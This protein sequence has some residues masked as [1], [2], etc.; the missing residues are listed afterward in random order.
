MSKCQFVC[1]LVFSIAAAVS[2][3]LVAIS[4]A[5]A[6]EDNCTQTGCPD[7]QTCAGHDGINYVC[8]PLPPPTEPDEPGEP[9][10]PGVYDPFALEEMQ[11]SE[12]LAHDLMNAGLTFEDYLAWKDDLAS[13]GVRV[14]GDDGVGYFIDE[15]L[16]EEAATPTEPVEP[17]TG[18]YSSGGFFLFQQ[19]FG[20]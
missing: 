19:M 2:V 10:E 13:E 7:G 14:H 20:W 18:T 6:W 1:Q 3:Q 17:P 16:A 5:D 15:V 9:G 11:I 12:S 4:P 8:V